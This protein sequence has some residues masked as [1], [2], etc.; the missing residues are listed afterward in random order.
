[1]PKTEKSRNKLLVMKMYHFLFNVI[2]TGVLLACFFVNAI[3]QSEEKFKIELTSAVPFVV[4]TS[5]LF[6]SVK[7]LH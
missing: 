4:E 3:A 2:F 5:L 7:A 1:M 6:F